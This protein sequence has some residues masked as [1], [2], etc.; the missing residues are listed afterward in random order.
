[1]HQ[2]ITL[3]SFAPYNRA[4]RLIERPICSGLVKVKDRRL[5]RTGLEV[6][7]TDVYAVVALKYKGKDD[8]PWIHT[9]E[10]V[11]DGQ[12]WW[13]VDKDGRLWDDPYSSVALIMS[14][15]MLLTLAKQSWDGLTQMGETDRKLIEEAIGAY[16]EGILGV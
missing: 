12:G 3:R 8:N 11:S 7:G 10:V 5:F 16:G 6:P 4:A 1:M 2:I 14:E 13:P 9:T 15:I